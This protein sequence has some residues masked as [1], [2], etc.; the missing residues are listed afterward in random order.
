VDANSDPQIAA[1]AWVVL[2]ALISC[3]AAIVA[4]VRSGRSVPLPGLRLRRRPPR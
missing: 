2:A 3:V 1:L 4:L